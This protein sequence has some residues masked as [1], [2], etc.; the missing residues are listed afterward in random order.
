MTPGRSDPKRSD[1]P[2][3]DFEVTTTTTTVSGSERQEGATGGS[4]KKKGCDFVSSAMTSQLWD[5]YLAKVKTVCVT[6]TMSTGTGSK[7][8]Q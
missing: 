6:T 3:S 2:R 5:I 8:R 1:D 7:K 4:S